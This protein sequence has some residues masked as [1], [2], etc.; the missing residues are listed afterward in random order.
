MAP[1]NGSE[2]GSGQHDIE[3]VVLDKAG[4]EARHAEP[5]SIR[6]STPVALGPGAVDLQ[7]GDFTLGAGD[8]S[9]GS[10]PTVSRPLGNDVF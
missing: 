6:H 8:V 5:V 3:I 4:N 10:G 9:M 7:S 1:V 2:L